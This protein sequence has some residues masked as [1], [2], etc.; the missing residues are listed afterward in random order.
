[1]PKIHANRSASAAAFQR[2][3]L[4]VANSKCPELTTT[5]GHG[6]IPTADLSL[7]VREEKRAGPGSYLFF[8]LNAVDSS[9]KVADEI[10][11]PVALREDIDEYFHALYRKIEV[12]DLRSRE[13]Q[14]QV[15]VSR[16]LA[17][18]GSALYD[19]IVPQDLGEIIWSIKDKAHS[20]Q[21]SMK[22]EGIPWEILRLTRRG[23]RGIE[24]GPF[25]CDAFAMS[26]W[27]ADYPQHLSFPLQKIAFIPP[28]DFCTGDDLCQ[29]IPGERVTRVK[30][31]FDEVF[32][33]LA[34][35]EFD[36]LHFSTHCVVERLRTRLLL[37]DWPLTPEDLAGEAGNL[38][39]LHPL[40]FLNG[41]ST[42]RGVNTLT[43]VTGWASA[44][45]KAGA[46][47]FIGTSWKVG[48]P[49]AAVFAKVFY[50]QFLS[51]V[52]IAD[53]VRAARRRLRR[54][55]NDFTWLGYALYAHPLAR[56]AP[57]STAGGET[58]GPL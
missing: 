31:N 39:E 1:M 22:G 58:L 57:V 7:F 54:D 28:A 53:A 34:S 29:S 27:L 17:A 36:G 33:I 47:A 19:S 38:A 35:G 10:F 55:Y 21:I 46:G 52:P 37:G 32:A 40:V 12:W 51:G 23:R 8:E 11:G 2:E 25:L 18:H 30:P 15:A 20:L 48:E 41:C 45:L 49:S 44:F 5:E 3:R 43:G 4:K 24:T 56:A 42:A 26:R 9:L 14:S 16:K 13:P 6:S 50:Q